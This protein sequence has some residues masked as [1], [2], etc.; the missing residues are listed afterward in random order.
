MTGQALGFVGLGR[1]GAPMAGRL[2]AA[3]HRLVAFDVA[4][5]VERLPEGS[6]AAASVA[7]VARQAD[8]VFLS[9]PDGAASK[10]VCRAVAATAERRARTVVDLSTIGIP[11][12]RECAALLE[13]GGIAYVDAPVSGGIAGARS[14]SLTIMAGAPAPLFEAVL[15]ILTVLARNAVRVGD[16]P[17]QGQ[18]MKLAN[19]FLS[20]TALAAASEAVVFGARFGLDMAR[21]IE[22][23]NVS[24]GRSAATEDKFPRSIVP[25]TYDF[26]FAGSLMTKDVTLY[27]ESAAQTGVLRAVGEV[28]ARLW[29]EYDEACP[30]TDFTYIH[31][32]VEEMT[33]E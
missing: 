30:G 26:G 22:V 32:Y 20:A 14:G 27:L 29:Q 13:A 16:E 18:A 10:A 15:P 1:M 25:R 5:T 2:V 11:A 8:V 23:I 19:N 33:G 21:M 6:L 9:L 3:G 4:G 12:A 7:G 17:G 28:V 24:T 31:K